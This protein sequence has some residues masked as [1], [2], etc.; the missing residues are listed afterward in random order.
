MNVIVMQSLLNY[1]K[2]KSDVA[3]SGQQALNLFFERL[4]KVKQG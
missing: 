1:K 2:V 4:E 3:M